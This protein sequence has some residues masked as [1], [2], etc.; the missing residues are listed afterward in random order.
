VSQSDFVTRGQAL[1]TAGQYQEAVK[2]CRLG[3]LGRPTTVEGRVVLGQALLALKR[4][5][6]VLAEMRVALELDH[7]SITAQVL[8][9]EALLR[10]GDSHGAIE[11][12]QRVRAQ[13]P[14]DPRVA[15]LIDEAERAVGR[16][17]ISAVHPAVGFISPGPPAGNP[18][19]PTRAYV[20]H[21]ADEEDTNPPEEEDTGG[22]F[23]RPTSLAP[24]AS[25]RGAPAAAQP[26]F[27]HA[28]PPPQV[29]Y[30]DATP[31]PAVLAVGDRSGTVEVDPELDGVEIGDDDFDDVASP[32]V[33]G[34]RA[35]AV[36]A[37][38]SQKP[39]PAKKKKGAQKEISTVELEDDEMIELDETHDPVPLKRPS[40]SA[41]RAAVKMPSGPLDAPKSPAANRPTAHQPA[42]APPAHLAQMIAN[43]PHEMRM[44]PLPP[45]RAPL[46]ASLPTAVAAIPQLPPQYAP[47]ANPFS[48]TM[49]PMGQPMQVQQQMPSPASAMPTMAIQ[50]QWP[51]TNKPLDQGLSPAQM[52]SAAAVDAMF[53]N[54][55]PA[56]SQRA[57][58]NEATAQPQP[59]PIDPAFAAML[60]QIPGVGPNDSVQSQSNAKGMKTGVRRGRSKLQIML[61][62][63]VGALVIGGGVGVGF[64]IRQM[65]LDKQ[66]GQA[67]EQAVALAK[68]DTWVGWVGARD[69]LAGIGHAR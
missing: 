64:K 42:V 57:A 7:T 53:G 63:F 49:M 31:P 28:S 50:P 5:D 32:P 21:A 61:W 68:L 55:D 1:V 12:F 6:E 40:Q 33:G 38:R 43:Q 14:T 67:R 2:V 36:P 15:Q 20:P 58:A 52:Q 29:E 9:G 51:G 69:R 27:G 60:D 24:P 8:K 56:W 39:Q 34:K 65:R 59:P 17:R 16:P 62:V 48:Q 22:S 23:T 46:A 25:K 19:F 11:V 30:G 66:I 26:L 3:L 37:P 44:Q 41:V 45:P 47:S 13:A 10:K 54:G 35:K 4:F 18:Q